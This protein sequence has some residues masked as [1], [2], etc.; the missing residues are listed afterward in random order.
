MDLIPLDDL[1]IK[2]HNAEVEFGLLLPYISVNE[3]F[4]VFAKAIHEY[5]QFLQDIKPVQIEMQQKPHQHL[6]EYGFFWYAK[7]DLSKTDGNNSTHWGT[8]GKYLYRFAVESSLGK[9]VD[10]VVDPFA[11]D[12]EM[13]KQSSFSIGENGS[14]SWRQSTDEKTWKTPKLNDLIVYEMMIHEFVGNF[15]KS[16]RM[17]DYLAD[18]GVNA[19]QIMPLSN[20]E[21]TIEWGYEPVFYFGVSERYGGSSQLKLFVSEAHKR[22]IAII[23]DLIWGHVSKKFPYV[24]LYDSMDF[25]P[26][27]RPFLNPSH[28]VHSPWGKTVD[29][30]KKFVQDFFFT[31]C[32]FWI[33]RFHFDGIRYDSLPDFYKD[34]VLNKGFSNLVYSVRQLVKSKS[35]DPDWS[36]FFNGTDALRLIQCADGL[37]APEQILNQTHCN[38]VW[39]DK[40]L[41]AAAQIAKGSKGVVDEF[42][43]KLALEGF[44]S[45]KSHEGEIMS[46]SAFQYIE[47]HDHSRFICNFNLLSDSIRS[48]LH[49]ELMYEGDRNLWFKVQPYLIALF[50][51]KGVPMLWQ[52]QEF[53]ENTYLPQI[54][55][56]NIR[57]LRS[58]RWDFFY[59]E[60]GGKTVNLIRKLI[61]I[62]KKRPQIR[63]GDFFI[64]ENTGTGFSEGLMAFTR[65]H[66]E[67]YTKV[68]LNFTNQ[69]KIASLKFEKPGLYIDDLHGNQKN[70][71]G[72]IVELDIPSNYGFIWSSVDA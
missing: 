36:R 47:N 62:R 16:L 61:R 32:N 23:A 9:L 57:I 25:P 19:L 56:G 64:P 8:P 70:I 28:S 6:N 41:T 15:N 46:V 49:N 60:P 69:N 13:G 1:S 38:C 50:M 12:Y 18:M 72:E 71:P 54:G 37:D 29:Y 22:G 67:D 26:D 52:G 66:D 68:I 27:R 3:G 35:N 45:K 63:L 55:L 44:P 30:N 14:F 58:L 43:K 17:L 2:T 11:R 24:H 33:D 53:L 21:R 48:D 42:A 65:M 4:R 20:V 5:D 40:T 59:D 31:V 7:V 51:A 34:D 10:W 39:Q